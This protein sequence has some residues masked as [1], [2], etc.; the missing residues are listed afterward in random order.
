MSYISEAQIEQDLLS[1]LKSLGYELVTIRDYNDLVVNFRKQLARLNQADLDTKKGSVSF[2]D[3]EFTQVL[4]NLEQDQVYE[5]AKCL[6]DQCLID[7]DNGK[8]IYL[9]LLHRDPARNI[10]Q[11]AHQI[12][13]E[14]D[15]LSTVEHDNRY[16]VTILV[17][18]LP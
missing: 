16:D 18:G 3:A 17:N 2:S 15:G 4:N 11:V 13:M 5:A 8:T 1:Q 9:D 7:L 14:R 10:F 6:R 12:K